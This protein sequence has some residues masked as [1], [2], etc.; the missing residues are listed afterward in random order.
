[1]LDVAL[2]P[3]VLRGSKD[4]TEVC[5]LAL[6]FAQKQYGLSLSQE[7]TVVS[8]SPKSS[9]DDL[10]RRL[11]FQQRPNASKQPDTGKAISLVNLLIRCRKYFLSGRFSFTAADVSSS[12]F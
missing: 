5:M 2:N 1:M 11:G 8:C 7:Y 10:H 6:S 3:A 9:P 4:N 12:T